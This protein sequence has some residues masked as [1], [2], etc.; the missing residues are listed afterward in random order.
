M[1]EAL[2]APAQ[3][4]RALDVLRGATLAL[5]IVV[6]MSISEALSY[7]P[8]LHAAWHGLTLTD[9]VFPTFLFVV[10]AALS[11]TLPGYERLGE[12]ALLAR[13]FRRSALIFLCGY[14]LYWFP[15]VH[16]GPDGGLALLPLA[17]T[18][19][20]GVLQRIALA[21]LIAALLLHYGGRR[22]ALI[23]GGAVL[24]LSW[25]GLVQWG[26]LSLAGNAARKLDLWLV[27]E[28]HMYRGEGIAF[29]PEGLL[30]TLPAVVHVLAGH[31]AAG[32]VQRRG[33][34]FESIAKLLMAGLLAIALALAWQSVLPINKKL[35]TSSYVLCTV[36]ID[37]CLLGL[38]VYAIDL[39]GWRR[40]SHFFEVFGKNTLF[41][42]LLAEIAMSLLWLLQLQGRPLFE[43]LY[44]RGFQSWAGDK[45]GSLLFALG[46]MLACWAVGAWLD[47]RRIY[48]R[49]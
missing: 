39:R 7:G 13:L 47:R 46:F 18:R 36:G 5:M 35:W 44:A 29:D 15:F 41:L 21:Y 30:G 14:L 32:L 4:S 28:A 45:P 6:N 10:G 42:Y 43:Q 20:L 37:L 9:V 23:Y 17:G 33:P 40:G 48:I 2:H 3:R 19:I 1:A 25:W 34:G 26:D 16:V 49:L 38:L 12:A 27:G 24:L 11:F 8:L 31:A 22:A